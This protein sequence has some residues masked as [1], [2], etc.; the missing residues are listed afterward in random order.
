MNILVN[1]ENNKVNEE[2]VNLSYR[3]KVL[4]CELQKQIQ[5]KQLKREKDNFEERNSR[6]NDFSIGNENA[7]SVNRL[8]E[9]DKNNEIQKSKYRKYD[10]DGKVVKGKGD[11]ENC[12]SL[13][14]KNNRAKGNGRKRGV[15]KPKDI[16]KNQVAKDLFNELKQQIAGNKPVRKIC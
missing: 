8:G 12:R 10:V 16:G 13:T 9:V 7:R 5:E 6:L 3:Q 14:P 11:K 15:K 4:Q 1:K 2:N